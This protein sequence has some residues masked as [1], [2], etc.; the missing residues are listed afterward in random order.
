MRGPLGERGQ[1]A[2]D[3]AGLPGHLDNGVPLPAHRVVGAGRPSVGGHQLRAV[4][5]TAALAAGQAGHRVPGATACRA[6]S[7]P[8]HAV[9]PRIST[10]IA[11]PP[12]GH[13]C[14]G[15]AWS[16]WSPLRWW[17]CSS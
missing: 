11:R 3:Q 10:F 15:Q 13:V 16:S 6:I 9:P 5:D 14:A 7:R 17:S 8:S 12:I 1:R 2:A 4:R